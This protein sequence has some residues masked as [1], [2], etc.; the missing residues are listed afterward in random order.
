MAPH[1]V[2][3]LLDLKPDVFD[4]RGGGPNRDRPRDRFEALEGGFQVIGAW[5]QTHEFVVPLFVRESGKGL[6]AGSGSGQLERHPP[7]G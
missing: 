4:H 5:R 6:R 2:M 1:F 7:D 3:P